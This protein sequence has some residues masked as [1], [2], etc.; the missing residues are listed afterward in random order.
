MRD[1]AAATEICYSLAASA[2]KIRRRGVV[3][4]KG[5]AGPF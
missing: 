5:V 2:L 3:D 1:H 4:M